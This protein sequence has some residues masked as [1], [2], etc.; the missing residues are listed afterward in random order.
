MMNWPTTGMYVCLE[1]LTKP[2]PSLTLKVTTRS[3][4]QTCS[5]RPCFATQ[6]L[7]VTWKCVD[8]VPTIPAASARS[9]FIAVHDGVFQS[10]SMG[11]PL[12]RTFLKDESI[13][14]SAA[15]V[16]CK[17]LNSIK[18]S[19]TRADQILFA[20]DLDL[21][22]PFWQCP[23]LDLYQRINKGLFRES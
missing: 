12:S 23:P 17:S 21:H 13:I 1:K 20:S 19:R 15:H 11:I 3:I 5:D 22:W 10:H 14:L 2:T 16:P 7:H 4:N 8:V 18:E 6:Y 9:L